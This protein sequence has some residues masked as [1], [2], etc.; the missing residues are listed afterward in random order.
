MPT[1]W[2]NQPKTEYDVA[3]PNYTLQSED[4]ESLLLENNQIIS[5]EH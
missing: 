3:S 5:I 2:T 4:G 1:D